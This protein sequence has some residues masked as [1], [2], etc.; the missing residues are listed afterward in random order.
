MSTQP[1]AVDWLSTTYQVR[2]LLVNVVVTLQPHLQF[3]G[4]KN[5]SRSSNGDYNDDDIVGV[6]LQMRIKLNLVWKKYIIESYFMV[7]FN[8]EKVKISFYFYFNGLKAVHQQ[9]FPLL[10]SLTLAKRALTPL[11]SQHLGGPVFHM[12]PDVTSIV[13][14]EALVY[15][16]IYTVC[17]IG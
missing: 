8:F 11:S 5:A 9:L 13:T 6:K 16:T 7:L 3:F 15:N 1:L 12:L 17:Q 14:H 4:K 2:G 10:S